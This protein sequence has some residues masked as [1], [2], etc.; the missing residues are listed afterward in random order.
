[1]YAGYLGRGLSIIANLLD[2]ELILLS[3]GVA[4]TSDA[5]IDEVERTMSGLVVGWSC[6]RIR[7]RVSEVARFG[8]VLG[9][10][11]VAFDGLNGR[12]GTAAG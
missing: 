3:G 10:T 5:L 11:A 12:P 9:A 7:L 6:R 8:G 2:P 4:E 1:M